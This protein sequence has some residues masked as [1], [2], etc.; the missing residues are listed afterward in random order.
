MEYRTTTYITA[1]IAHWNA[2][3]RGVHGHYDSPYIESRKGSEC[4]TPSYLPDHR[5][6]STDRTFRE[7]GLMIDYD[8]EIKKRL[9]K[10]STEYVTDSDTE[11]DYNKTLYLPHHEVLK[12][13]DKLSQL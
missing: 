7:K 9:D 2:K 4:L 3:L 8:V 10:K 13:K 6:L 12:K 11:P 1:V 5:L